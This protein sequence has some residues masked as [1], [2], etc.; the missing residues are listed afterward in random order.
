MIV[1]LLDVINVPRQVDDCMKACGK[2][3]GRA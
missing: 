2:E 3:L 1:H